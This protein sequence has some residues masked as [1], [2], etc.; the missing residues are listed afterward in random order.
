MSTTVQEVIRIKAL[1]KYGVQVEDGSYVNYGKFIKD[2]E[3]NK[4][5]PGMAFEAEL[6][7]SDK[8]TKYINK[9]GRQVGEM[10]TPPPTGQVLPKVLKPHTAKSSLDGNVKPEINGG[11]YKA[12]DFDAEARGKTRC[13]GFEAGLSSPFTATLATA[14]EVI[15]F[16][17]TVSDACVRHVFGEDK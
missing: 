14:D 6:F 3:K 8:G 11:T 9:L 1:S 4:V 10:T 17:Q 7:V 2:E 13:A 12:R 16:A 5:V 15:A